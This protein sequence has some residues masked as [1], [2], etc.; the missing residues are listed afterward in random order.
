VWRGDDWQNTQIDS[1]RI[2]DVD[3]DLALTERLALF[4]GR[5]VDEV[6]FDGAL[7]FVGARAGNENVGDM[8]L[9]VTNRSPAVGL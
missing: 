9:D 1:R 8:R 5:I 2:V 4:R 6:S 7:E 3:F